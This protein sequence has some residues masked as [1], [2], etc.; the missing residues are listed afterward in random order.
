MR[1]FSVLSQPVLNH[2]LL[3]FLNEYE[4]T[5]QSGSY[6]WA[7]AETIAKNMRIIFDSVAPFPAKNKALALAIEAAGKMN[8]FA[9]METCFAMI[10]SVTDEQLGLVVGDVMK[11]AGYS[12]L[13]NLERSSCHSE[14][15]RKAVVFIKETNE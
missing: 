6:S 13:T 1:I 5:V 9:A 15:V 12:F 14:A 2:I 11:Q 8:R 3:P 4:K 10:T 7:F